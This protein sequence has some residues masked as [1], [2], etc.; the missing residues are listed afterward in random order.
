MLVR[1]FVFFGSLLVLALCA[2]L[3]GP[4]FID[5]TS[6]RADFEREASAILGRKVE[7]RGEASARILPFPSVSFTDVVVSSNRDDTPAMVAES[8]SMDAELAP[9]LRGE[10]LIFDMRLVRPKAELAVREDGSLDWAVAPSTPVDPAQ[11]TIENLSVVEGQML[12]RD[13]STGRQLRLNEINADVS[14]KSLNGPWRGAGSLRVNGR[15]ATLSATTGV[16]DGSGEMSLSLTANPEGFPLK[17]DGEGRLSSGEGQLRY[18]GKFRAVGVPPVSAELRDGEGKTARPEAQVARN[19]ATGEFRLSRER[20][21]VDSFRFES[22]PISDPY[23]AEGSAFLDLGT[24]PRFSIEATGQQFNVPDE[25]NGA[26]GGMS[27]GERIAEIEDTLALVP[28]PTIPGSVNIKLPAVVAGH[29]T[30]R[31]LALSARPENKGWR[32]LSASAQLPGRSTLELDG[33]LTGGEKPKFQGNLLLAVKQ[34][35]GFAAWLSRDIEDAV[36]ALPAAGFRAAVAIDGTRQSFS[37]MELILGPTKLTGAVERTSLPTAKPVIVARLAGDTVDADTAA[38]F[39][40]LLGEG[41]VREHDLDVSIKAGT[42]AVGG[43]E[44][45]AVDAAGRLTGEQLDVDRFSIGDLAGASVA[46]TGTVRGLNTEPISDVDVTIA[47]ADLTPLANQVARW[48]PGSLLATELAERANANPGLLSDARLDFT[49]SSSAKTLV[50]VMTEGAL[51]FSGTVGATK[52]QGTVSRDSDVLKGAVEFAN[53]D[54]TPLLALAG[55]PTLPVISLGPGKLN[56]T[57]ERRDD[58]TFATKTA[59]EGDGFN[60]VFDGVSDPAFAARGKLSLRA[61]DVEPWLLAVGT[62]VP[63]MGFGTSA[64]LQ[65]D[66]DYSQQLLVLNDLAGTIGEASVTGDVNVKFDAGRPDVSGALALDTLD[67]EP[68]AAALFGA[69]ALMSSDGLDWP[70][71]AFVDKA[72][73]PVIADLDLTVGTLAAGILPPVYDATLSMKLTDT[74]LAVTDL[75]GKSAEGALNGR[76]DLTNEAGNGLVSGQLTLKDANLSTLLPSVGIAAPAIKG[77]SDVSVSVTSAGRSLDAIVTGLSGTGVVNLRG[78]EVDGLNDAALPELIKRADALGQGIDEAA[79]KGFAPALL[80]AGKFDTGDAAV[81]F[82][83][84]SGVARV[85]AVRFDRDKAVLAAEGRIDIGAQKLEAAAD[86][87]FKPGDDALVGAEPGVRFDLSGPVGEPKVALD[88]SGLTQFLTQRQLEI[89]QARVEAMQASIMEKQRLRRE[90]ARYT[91]LNAQR[92]AVKE[93]EARTK[94]VLIRQAAEAEARRIKQEVEDR[95]KAE[96]KAKAEAAANSKPV[97]KPAKPAPAPQSAASK[98]KQQPVGAIG[99]FPPPPAAN[100]APEFS[101][102]DFDG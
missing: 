69:P 85:P 82:N 81:A 34:P 43:I 5:W 15:R 101:D 74:Q 3:V 48:M 2:A 14:A 76:V 23:S 97:I 29:T 84:A 98:P 26:N 66:A 20:L 33:Y 90:A 40:A 88:T 56:A 10:I 7:V 35:T 1:L 73:T 80:Q 41:T 22:G 16:A 58:K 6:Y 11:V 24:D 25:T 49:G 83:I 21:D 46:A 92:A 37:D 86:F 50:K 99:E 77:R 79:T 51:S 31:D 47:A 87:T 19:R 52:L 53:E 102:P 61:D 71:G 13:T 96:E 65:A 54:A 18:A 27:L 95:A 63:G 17:L 36:R 9:F 94:A 72:S 39:A 12:V 89:E 70:A 4:Y 68:M 28:E 60:L 42:L 100:G 75:A 78:V 32:I 57:I 91:A 64:E 93:T 44:V 55:L 62:P 59:L 67:L 30:I 45:A 38:A 8:F